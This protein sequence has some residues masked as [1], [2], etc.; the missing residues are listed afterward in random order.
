MFVLLRTKRM[1]LR[2]HAHTQTVMRSQRW[3]SYAMHIYSI[4]F[5]MLEAREN[6]IALGKSLAVLRKCAR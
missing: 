6:E 4:K 5:R 1:H 3:K 2:N